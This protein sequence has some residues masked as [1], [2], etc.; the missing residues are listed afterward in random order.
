MNSPIPRKWRKPVAFAL[1]SSVGAISSFGVALGLD[2]ALLM[3]LAVAS[4]CFCC[5]NVLEW[6]DRCLAWPVQVVCACVWA[7]PAAAYSQPFALLKLVFLTAAG[8]LLASDVRSE[9]FAPPEV[10]P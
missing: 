1:G 9:S 3:P 8:Y 5:A 6:K 2:H 10:T 7:A 4:V